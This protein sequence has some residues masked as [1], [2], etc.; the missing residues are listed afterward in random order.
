M[1][2]Y[3][4]CRFATKEKADSS[5]AYLSSP[6]CP[7]PLDRK[8]LTVEPYDLARHERLT[9]DYPFPSAWENPV[10]LPHIILREHGPVRS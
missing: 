9:N 8:D 10:Y 1:P 2:E 7:E 5:V 6:A 3:G 4:L